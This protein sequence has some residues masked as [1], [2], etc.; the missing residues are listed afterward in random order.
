MDV[1]IGSDIYLSFSLLSGGM[2]LSLQ[3][4]RLRIPKLP[5]AELGRANPQLLPRLS[6]LAAP[7]LRFS[8]LVRFVS[9]HL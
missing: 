8:P 7:R 9:H 5:R 2:N 6:P 3:G 1:D 4:P